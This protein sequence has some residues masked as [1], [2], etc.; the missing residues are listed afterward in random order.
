MPHSSVIPNHVNGDARLKIGRRLGALEGARSAIRKK[1]N[2][3]PNQYHGLKH[4][5]PKTI[6]LKAC[7]AIFGMLTKVSLRTDTHDTS[8]G[9]ASKK[10]TL[11]SSVPRYINRCMV[12]QM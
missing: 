5:I 11:Q 6:R 2:L 1:F 3:K 9:L 4:F 8:L 7:S 12:S 10:L